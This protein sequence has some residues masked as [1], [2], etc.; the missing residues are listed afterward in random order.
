MGKRVPGRVGRTVLLTARTEGVNPWRPMT[1]TG[2]SMVFQGCQDAR[3]TECLSQGAQL[4]LK[5]ASGQARG[6][7]WD[8]KAGG[9]YFQSI[10]RIISQLSP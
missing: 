2:I 9:S 7:S 3:E 6:P 5:H 4:A 1:R 10:R 8:P